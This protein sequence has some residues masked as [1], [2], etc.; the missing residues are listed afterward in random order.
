MNFMDNNVTCWGKRP[1]YL[2]D[3]LKDLANVL[4]FLI[5]R[6][7]PLGDLDVQI[8]R[9]QLLTSKNPSADVPT[10]RR[11]SIDLYGSELALLAEHGRCQFRQDTCDLV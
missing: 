6:V 7:G 3:S 9:H 10:L 8:E 11:S 1:K 5:L 2:S 4:T